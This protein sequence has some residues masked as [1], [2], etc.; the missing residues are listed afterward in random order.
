MSWHKLKLDFNGESSYFL[1][2]YE[3]VQADRGSGKERA[4]A[5]V[6]RQEAIAWEVLMPTRST[7]IQSFS[8]G[9]L[10]A[11]SFLATLVGF[12]SRSRSLAFALSL[13]LS[14][15]NTAHTISARPA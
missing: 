15:T 4:S 13:S 5:Q 9:W 8:W 7:H 11:L 2:S 1:V 14:T 6:R 10:E 12:L 3:R